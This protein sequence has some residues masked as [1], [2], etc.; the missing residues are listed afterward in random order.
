MTE[1]WTKREEKLYRIELEKYY[2][3]ENKSIR[4][5]SAILDIGQSTVYDRLI[6]LGITPTRSNKL[7]FNNKR[8]DISIPTRFSGK[9]AEFIGIM[10][11]DGH[12]TP[13]QVTVTLGN[14]EKSYTRY[15]A[16]LIKDI[17]NIEPK[18]I[19]VGNGYCVIYFGSTDVVNW[20]LS[21]GLVFNKVKKQVDAPSWIFSKV[22]YMNRFLKG[23]F[24]TD[25]SIYKLRFGVQLAFT[26]RSIPLLKSLQKCLFLMGYSPSK[27]SDFRIYLTK[28]KDIADFF[29]TVK[30]TN[31]KHKD[32]FKMFLL[33]K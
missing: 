10:L 5:V 33:R 11:G 21:M 32:R 8:N 29:E 24:D 4:E 31:K 12:I 9:L 25:G 19:T 1:K 26:N 30:P 2:I 20:L 7:G 18:I 22:D 17:F 6:R 3:D 28:Q 15:V 23:F 13:T 16:K 14:K 27:L